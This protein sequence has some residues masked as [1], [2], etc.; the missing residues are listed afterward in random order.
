MSVATGVKQF[1]KPEWSSPPSQCLHWINGEPQPSVSG[2]FFDSVNPAFGVAH[3][4][5]ALGEVSDIEYAVVSAQN[6]FNKHQTLTRED[7]AKILR[8]IG[9]KILF[10]R[11]ELASIETL[12]NGKPISESFHGD[13]VRAAQNFHFF[14]DLIS[15]QKFDHFETESAGHR[16][17]VTKEPLGVVGLITPWNFPLHLATWK[18]APALAQGNAVILKPAELTPLSVQLIARIAQECDLPAGLL[19]IVQGMGAGGA[20]EALVT[21]PQVRAISFTGETSTGVAIMQAASKTLK[22][23]SFEL[24][25]KGASVI[26]DDA[27]LDA[28]LPAICNAAFRNQGQVCLAGS[29][30][31]VSEKRYEELTEGLLRF[32]K[33]I[34][35]GDPQ[36]TDTTMGALISFEHR[37]KVQ[38]YIQLCRDDKSNGKILFGG[39]I[40][41]FEDTKLNQGYFLEPTIIDEVQQNSSLIQEEIFGPVVT[42]QKFK[43][44]DEAC[45]LVNGTPYGLSC[46]AFTSNYKVAQTFAKAAKFGMVW[47]NGWNVRDLNTPFGG[48]KRSGIG[49]EGGQYSLDF[50][51]DHKTTTWCQ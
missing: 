19:N 18:I 4:Q 38:R 29:R 47:I 20:G 50:F 9:D 11:A 13:V 15:S 7:R 23:I 5:V 17:I 21:H 33:S 48:M 40:P 42:I 49:R 10:Y 3:S 2:K 30:I 41:K 12:D 43:S 8:K 46:S 44:F 28:Y 34:K 14:A 25:G 24:G 27:D 51:I 1:Q 37:Q 36:R 45:A 32:A 31:I 35:V 22:K 6:A 16:H 39:N 26:F